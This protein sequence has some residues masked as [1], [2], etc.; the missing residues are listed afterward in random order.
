LSLLRIWVEPRG[1]THTEPDVKPPKPN[2]FM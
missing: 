2:F 1:A